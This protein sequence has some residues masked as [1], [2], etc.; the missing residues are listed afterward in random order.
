MELT[1]SRLAQVFLQGDNY[2]LVLSENKLKFISKFNT[3]E[4]LFE[5]WNGSVTVRRGFLWGSLD[6]H[7]S[8][9]RPKWQ[10]FGLPWWKCKTAAELLSQQHLDWKNAC[11]ARLAALLPELELKIEQLLNTNQYI[12]HSTVTRLTHELQHAFHLADMSYELARILMPTRV[13]PIL[14]WITQA[15][16]WAAQFNQQ[17]ITVEQQRWQEWFSS[18]E[19]HPLNPSQQQAVLVNDDHN[20]VLAG[21]GSGK[22]SVLMARVGYLLN[23][24]KAQANEILLLAF[25]RQA[26]KEMSQRLVEKLGVTLGKQVKVVTFHQLALEVIR[27]VE[28]SAPLIS[29]LATDKEAKSLWLSEQLCQHWQ[30]EAVIKR[31]HKHHQQ[32]PLAKLKPDELLIEQ[33]GNPL[34][35]DWVFDQIDAVNVH[36]LS[37]KKEI[38]A[39]LEQHHEFAKLKSELNLI[40]P[41]YKAYLKVLKQSNS[42]DFN[43]MINKATVYLSKGKYP[44]VYQFVMVDEYQDISPQRLQLLESICNHSNASLFAV[45]DDWQ[46]IYRFTGADVNLTTGFEQRFGQ[47]KLSFL[48]TTYR[49]NSQIGAVANRFIQQNPAQIKKILNSVKQQKQK[50]VT[51]INHDELASTLKSLNDKGKNGESVLLIGR[52]HYH[53]PKE[54]TLWCNEFLNLKLE[55]STCHSSKGREADYVVVLCVDKGQFPPFTRQ[56]SL[57]DGLLPTEDQYAHA[58]ERRLFYVALTRAKKRVWLTVT[59]DPSPFITELKDGDYPV[60][61]K[62]KKQ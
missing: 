17:W 24:G 40:W 9:N 46:A 45:G 16:E 39:H 21:A 27:E 58:E 19:S 25:G 3:D 1:A 20:L 13:E 38:I 31:W 50:A 10:V 32:W 5:Q 61:F 23:S 22:T 37:T 14:G 47:C 60:V 54:L 49:F 29:S 56:V 6:F 44:S 12:K 11:M 52:N 51:V 18:C 4:L 33:H 43:S 36:Q 48:D 59:K 8:D 28:Y 30:S 15:D 53:Q 57:K 26:A 55:F 42:Y 7:D 34:L 41:L 62:I 2:Q 35:H